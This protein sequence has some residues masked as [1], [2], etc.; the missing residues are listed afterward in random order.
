MI[1][2]IA[3]N[4]FDPRAVQLPPITKAQSDSYKE[5]ASAAIASFI[6]LGATKDEET[7]LKKQIQTLMKSGLTSR[8]L[9]LVFKR[10]ARDKEAD[11]LQQLKYVRTVLKL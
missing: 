5:I 2:G 6:E 9:D 8:D 7:T 3:F 11:Y 10:L 1:R 4:R